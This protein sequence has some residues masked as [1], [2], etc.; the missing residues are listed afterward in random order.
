MDT[1][2][3][4]TVIESPG[5]DA[6]T[7]TGTIGPLPSM[8]AALAWLSE[9]VPN[10]PPLDGLDDSQGCTLTV[11]DHVYVIEPLIATWDVAPVAGPD[12]LYAP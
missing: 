3:A 7:L 4:I 9:R 5:T 6:W 11:G 1:K 8:P 2:Y 10:L 12:P